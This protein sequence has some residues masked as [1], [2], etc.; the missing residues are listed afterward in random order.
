MIETGN[1]T[2]GESVGVDCVKENGRCGSRSKDRSVV[3][4]NDSDP[5]CRVSQGL[6]QGSKVSQEGSTLVHQTGGPSGH[7]MEH[8]WGLGSEDQSVHKPK[9][10]PGRGR[11]AGKSAPPVMKDRPGLPLRRRLGEYRKGRRPYPKGGNW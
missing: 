4:R 9:A 1:G 7:P 10:V 6:G 8:T 3:A 11:V 5:V 2:I